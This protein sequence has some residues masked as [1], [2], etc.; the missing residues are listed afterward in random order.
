V[1]R[2][3]KRVRE[4]KCIPFDLDENVHVSFKPEHIN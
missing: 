1:T 2:H 4:L 3:H